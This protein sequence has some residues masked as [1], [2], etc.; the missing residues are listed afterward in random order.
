MNTTFLKRILLAC[1]VMTLAAGAAK[2]VDPLNGDDANDGSI[3]A[4]WKTL[5]KIHNLADTVYIS[6]SAVCYFGDT[7]DRMPQDVTL[8][9]W[10]SARPTVIVSNRTGTAAIYLNSAAAQAIHAFDIKW[11]VASD[12]AGIIFYGRLGARTIEVVNCE[13][14]MTGSVAA[15]RRFHL[16]NTGLLF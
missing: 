15:A 10:G 3:A 4:P 11:T 16:R 9:P 6:D 2:Y 13:F 7:H 5:V 12:Y 1:T 8:R 14:D